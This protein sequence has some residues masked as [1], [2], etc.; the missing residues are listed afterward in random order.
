MAIGAIA[1]DGNGRV[2][3]GSVRVYTRVRTVDLFPVFY[4]LVCK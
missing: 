1:N 3:S 4:V 2:S